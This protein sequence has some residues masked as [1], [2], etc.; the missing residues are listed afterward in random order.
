MGSLLVDKFIDL[1]AIDLTE[2]VVQL[3]KR[4]VPVTALGQ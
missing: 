3:P 2:E 4:L 1:L